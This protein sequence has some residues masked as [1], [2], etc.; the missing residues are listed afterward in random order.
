MFWRKR[1]K[2]K[3]FAEGLIGKIANDVYGDWKGIASTIK[4]MVERTIEGT[5]DFEVPESHAPFVIAA[6]VVGDLQAV[7]NLRGQ[8]EYMILRKHVTSAF[9]RVVKLEAV[10]ELISNYEN[11]F[12]EAIN[13]GEDPI[14]Y[15]IASVLYD[16]L[17]IPC[18]NPEDEKGISRSLLQNPLVLA[19]LGTI[20]VSHIGFTKH[21]LENY[22]VVVE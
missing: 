18:P 11:E 7:R 10:Q 15:G 6:A 20:L 22:K 1:L 2:G 8:Y 3:H 17:E 19:W 5:K 14:T 16:L 4:D 12:Y 9:S 13:R 21:A